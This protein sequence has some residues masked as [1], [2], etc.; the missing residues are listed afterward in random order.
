MSLCAVETDDEKKEQYSPWPSFI[1]EEIL[2]ERA[3]LRVAMKEDMKSYKSF[4]D[5]HMKRFREWWKRLDATSKMRCVCLWLLTSA[6]SGIGSASAWSVVLTLRL[7]M[8][9]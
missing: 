7:I 9:L 4:A 2:T 6:T 3:R 5:E 8:R 1:H